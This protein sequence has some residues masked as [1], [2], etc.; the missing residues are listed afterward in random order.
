LLDDKKTLH[1]NNY[2]AGRA[3]LKDVPGIATWMLDYK[4][5]QDWPGAQAIFSKRTCDFLE[6]SK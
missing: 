3:H 6:V 1:F 4:N 2:R 5:K